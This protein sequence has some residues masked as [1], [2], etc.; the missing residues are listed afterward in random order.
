MERGRATAAAAVARSK[1]AGQIA[2]A[3]PAL[4]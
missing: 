2:A 1:I 3:Q 4:P